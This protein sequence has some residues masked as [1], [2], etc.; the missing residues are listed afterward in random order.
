MLFFPW[1]IEDRNEIPGHFEPTKEELS[2]AERFFPE[3]PAYRKYAKLKWRRLKVEDAFA[4]G[5]EGDKLFRQENPATVEEA[6]VSD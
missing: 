5:E 4:I 1:Y 2:V 3:L 6:F